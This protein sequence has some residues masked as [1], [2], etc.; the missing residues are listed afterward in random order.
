[1]IAGVGAATRSPRC[2]SAL[3]AATRRY[4]LPLGATRCYPLPRR[5]FLAGGDKPG[6]AAL[7]AA[8]RPAGRW[9]NS[10]RAP[11]RCAGC[12]ARGMGDGAVITMRSRIAAALRSGKPGAALCH[13]VTTDVTGRYARL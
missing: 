8:A 2:H 7:W 12:G 11:H 3:P 1:M 13:W 6:A 9:A 5:V 4:P 10:A